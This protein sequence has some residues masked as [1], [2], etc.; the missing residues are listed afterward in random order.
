[1]E[2][3]HTKNGSL[4]FV[5][6]KFPEKRKREKNNEVRERE[7]KNKRDK[8]KGKN[9][10]KR[11]RE[12]TN[13]RLAKATPRAMDLILSVYWGVR[14]RKRREKGKRKRERGERREEGRKK[15]PGSHGMFST[16]RRHYSY[17][18]STREERKRKEKC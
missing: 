15:K 5:A 4:R 7:G 18:S 1:M 10:E 14:E 12:R 9:G 13:L 8:I 11:E 2:K 3:V 6:H 17:L 16:P